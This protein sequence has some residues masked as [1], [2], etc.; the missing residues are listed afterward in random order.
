MNKNPLFLSVLRSVQRALLF[1]I[2]PSFVAISVDLS[3]YNVFLMRVQL[4]I[5]PDEDDKDLCFAAAAEVCGDFVEIRNSEVTFI[6]SNLICAVK[7]HF[8]ALV[9]ARAEN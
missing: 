4:D 5:E 9:Y 3:D 1:N 8:P 7:D 2:R 6:T